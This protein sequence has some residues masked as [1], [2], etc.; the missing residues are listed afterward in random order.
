M[1]CKSFR[2]WE[3]ALA[4]LAG[5]VVFVGWRAAGVLRERFCVREASVAGFAADRPVGG[6]V[7]VMLAESL[8]ILE[9]F[10]AVVAIRHGSAVTD[11]G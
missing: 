7:F 10:P 6:R 9:G 2:A 1:L 4:R 5:V 3:R 11:S 8:F